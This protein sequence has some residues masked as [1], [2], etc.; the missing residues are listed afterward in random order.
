ML[1]IGNDEMNKADKKVQ[2]MKQLYVDAVEELPPNA[3]PPRGKAVQ[4]NCFV[5]SDHAGD[6]TTRRSRTGFIIMLNNAPIYWFS[7]KQT[8]VETSSFGSEF[9]AMKTCCEYI[10]GLRYKLR[11]MGIPVDFPTYVFGDNQSVLSNTLKPHS[12]LKK[13]SSSIAFHFTREGVAKDEWR[14]TYIS[15]HDKNPFICEPNSFGGE[16]I[17]HGKCLFVIP[18][19]KTKISPFSQHYR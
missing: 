17:R 11:M 16:T 9:I 13:K 4:I 14:V 19:R 3:P 15:T 5:D 18:N 8:S 2:A 6:S 10:R 12:S 7:K 1:I